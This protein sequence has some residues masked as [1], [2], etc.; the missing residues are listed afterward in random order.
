MAMTALNM[1]TATISMKK[2]KTKSARLG[3]ELSS[4]IVSSNAPSII[5]YTLRRAPCGEFA[6]VL[7]VDPGMMFDGIRR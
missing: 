1:K 2:T 5:T 4:N 6:N 3:N 7:R